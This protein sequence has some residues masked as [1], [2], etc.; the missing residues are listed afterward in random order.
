MFSIHDIWRQ[1]TPL[2]HED[3]GDVAYNMWI[4]PL[5]P[6]EMT[7]KDFILKLPS[8]V[9]RDI[10]STRFLDCYIRPRVNETLGI[11]M[12]VKLVL[13]DE[14]ERRISLNLDFMDPEFDYDFDN[15]IVGPNN[16]FAHAAATAVSQ[17]PGGTYNPLFIYGPCGIG[18]THLLF[19]IRNQILRVNPNAKIIYIKGD[20]FTNELIESVSKSSMAEFRNKYRVADVFLMDDVQFIGG[21]VSTQEEFFHT[22]ETLYQNHKQIVLTSDRPPKEINTLEERLRSRFE[23]GLLADIQP[24]EFETRVAIVKRKA[25]YF[26]LDIPDSTCEFIATKVKDNVRQLEGVVKK[27]NIMCVMDKERPTIATATTII[28]ELETDVEESLPAIIER[29]VTEVSRA[30]EVSPEDIYSRRHAQQISL[31]RQSCMYCVR[32]TTNMSYED[33][34]NSFGGRDHTTVMYACQRVQQLVEQ[35][36]DFRAMIQ[37]I[38]KNVRS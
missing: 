21:K 5:Q 28:K 18:K 12:N 4:K 24:P 38:I 34:G 37:D 9:H 13:E 23:N 10:V 15:F 7:S 29:I 26:N 33:I 30:L 32:E 36:S 2:L 35:K 16:R 22:F 27:M 20:Q 17:N 6:V 1:I 19:A 31:A 25:A 8:T 11:E 14:I 3:V